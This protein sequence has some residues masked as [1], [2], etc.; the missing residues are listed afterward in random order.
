MIFDI[1]RKKLSKK[2]VSRKIKRPILL[3]FT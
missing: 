1:N 3:I 2:E